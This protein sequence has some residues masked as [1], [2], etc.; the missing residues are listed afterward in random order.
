VSEQSCDTMVA[1]H[2]A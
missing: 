2:A 1:D